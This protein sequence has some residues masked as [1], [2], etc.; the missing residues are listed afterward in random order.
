MKKKRMPKS[1][2]KHIRLEKARIRREN[3]SLKK[4]QELIDQLYQKQIKTK[5]SIINEDTRNLQSSN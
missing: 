3:L 1:I 2:R 5:N 4:Q